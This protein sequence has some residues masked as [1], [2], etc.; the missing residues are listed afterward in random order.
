MLSGRVKCL[1]LSLESFYKYY[2]YKY[3]Y[4]VY[5]Y[6]FDPLYSDSYISAILVCKHTIQ[7][8]SKTA[9]RH[10]DPK[11]GPS[12]PKP[13]PNSMKVNIVELN[14]NTIHFKFTFNSLLIQSSH[15]CKNAFTFNSFLTRSLHVYKNA[16]TCNSPLI[17]L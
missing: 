17:H 14:I 5:V 12:R 3:D 15:V 11:W 13:C 16:F 8:R 4:P 9:Q 6:Y 10:P 1:K 7:Q 2:N